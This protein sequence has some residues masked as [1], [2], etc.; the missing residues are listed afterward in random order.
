MKP[1][2]G[3]DHEL[4]PR[5][6]PAGRDR[7]AGEVTICFLKKTAVSGAAGSATDGAV[8]LGVLSRDSNAIYLAVLQGFKIGDQ[9]IWVTAIIASTLVQGLPVELEFSATYANLDSYVQLLDHARR[10]TKG[11]VSAIEAGI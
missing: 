8:I 10:V 2:A 1:A 4:Q 11:F 6:L 3:R 5:L 7:D 9:R